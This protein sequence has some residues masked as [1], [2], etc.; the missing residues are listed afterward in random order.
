[1]KFKM[2]R[3]VNVE[4][5]ADGKICLS[6]SLTQQQ[7]YGD[8]R[9]LD[10]YSFFAAKHSKT[11][12][13]RRFAEKLPPLELNRLW[14]ALEQ[15]GFL[16]KRDTETIF[17]FISP[18]EHT[19]KQGYR[20][21]RI[22][23]TDACNLACAYCKVM[24]NIAQTAK[25]PL[26]YSDLE[27]AIRMFFSGSD[28]HQPKIV[29]V[30]GGEPLTKWDGIVHVAQLIEKYRRCSERYYLAIG[31]NG[32]LLTMERVK[33]L[34]EHNARLVVSLDGTK[35]SHDLLRRDHKNRGSYDRTVHGI[36]LLRKAGIEYG[37]SM[38]IGKHNIGCL[39]EEIG[40]VINHFRP[41]SLGINFMKPPTRNQ[42][43]FPYLILPQEYVTAV[44]SA[45][46]T[47]R[48]TGVF[49]E[50][51]YRKLQPFVTRKFRY[52]DCGA[53]AGTTINL[54][55]RGRIGPCKS[56]LVL[57]E[58]VT[59]MR[60]QIALHGKKLPIVDAM[61]K[62]SPVY[63]AGCW[64]CPGIAI[65]GKGCAYEAWAESGSMMNI[66]SRACVYTQLFHRQFIED[67]A[68]F[69]SQKSSRQSFYI[70]SHADRQHLFGK[71]AVN[72]DTLSSSIGHA[73]DG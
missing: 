11:A 21:L 55:A 53:A 42:R 67:L 18:E 48:D 20:L 36:N 6:H 17:N 51:V 57:D 32:T 1:M 12:F 38:V 56:F 59:D 62:R 72:E 28:E 66:D 43:D 10:V 30:S 41:V 27:A 29:H 33:V 15:D 58:L 60:D 68:D 45:F 39:T 4:A 34:R 52:H 40:N 69:L 46:K 61:Q 47:H 19:R 14:K 7:I 26:S 50:L 31:T 9:L 37:L 64:T 8:R 25:T 35:E 73:T 70:P 23:L 24:P 44:Y 63:E 13:E 2:S 16:T 54:D 3:F 71:M 22:L 5:L 49:F 65:C